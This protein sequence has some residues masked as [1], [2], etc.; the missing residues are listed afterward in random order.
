MNLHTL[1][2]DDDLLKKFKID[3]EMLPKILPCD[4]H[5]GNI[6]SF[7]NAPLLAIIGDQQSSMVGQGVIS[8]GES[9]VTF[10]TGGFVLTN[11]G[12]NSSNKDFPNL[13]TTVA[14][15]I[16]GRTDYAI[17]GSIYS[18]CSAVN[19]LKSLGLFVNVQDTEKMAQS[20]SSNEGVYFVPA[21]TGLGAP[22]WKD[23]SRGAILGMTYDTT[24]NHIV[25][26]CLE[27]MAY[28]T[29]AVFDEIK[30]NGQKLGLIS[31][32]GGGSKNN[33]V[34]QFLADMLNH[35]IV[36]S[37][38]S[39]A[40]V[41]GA[42]YIALLNLGIL[43]RADIKELTSSNKIYEPKMTESE[44]KHLYDGWIKAIKKV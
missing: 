39:E 2:W 17:E 31:V 1:D 18:A 6:K 27:S 44:R 10:G 7:L 5:F 25:R 37:K 15:T 35:K 12:E 42:I 28:N 41:M 29:K 32:D 20:L 34:L 23:D 3:K 9:K 11:L 26:A 16:H 13:L 14:R 38:E 43:C 8:A 21:F 24:K 33:F 4:A 30:Q 22:Y 36:K 40:T 19:F